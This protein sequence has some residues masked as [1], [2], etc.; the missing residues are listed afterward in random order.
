MSKILI[1]GSRGS[2]GTNLI[3]FLKEKEHEVI[4]I[5][6]DIR[7]YTSLRNEMTRHKNADW[8]VHLAA[9]VN[10]VTCDLAGRHSYEVNVIGTHNVAE[11]TKEIKAKYCYFST[12]AIYQPGV[13]PIMEDSPKNPATLYGFTKY[14]G[15][16]TSEFLYKNDK[17][18]LLII[19]PC[20]AFGGVDDHSIRS[21]ERRVGKECRSRW[22]PYH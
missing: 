11:L 19:R 6:S 14:M 8:V 5:T 9:I 17:N 22:S 12:T 16:L 13:E 15:E 21:E 2:I 20:F 4:E 10:T 1:T 7:D 18:K 3:P